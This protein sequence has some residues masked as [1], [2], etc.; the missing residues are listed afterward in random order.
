MSSLLWGFVCGNSDALLIQLD[1]SS[2]KHGDQDRFRYYSPVSLSS[3]CPSSCS[4]ML[5]DL[6]LFFVVSSRHF[7]VCFAERVSIFPATVILYLVN[8]ESNGMC[9]VLL[10]HS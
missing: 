8:T 2:D 4:Y 1:S 7:P 10:R 9:I 6:V 5:S 3:P